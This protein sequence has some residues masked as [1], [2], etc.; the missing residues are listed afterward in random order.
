MKK[1]SCSE[2]LAEIQEFI[3]NHMI[4]M[5]LD[6][7]EFLKKEILIEKFLKERWE[8]ANAGEKQITEK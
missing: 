1:Q 5:A 2:C 7:H 8:K 6:S 3:L 4:V